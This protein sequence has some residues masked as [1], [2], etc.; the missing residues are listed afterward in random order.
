[1]VRHQAMQ[2]R[3]TNIIFD[4][5]SYSADVPVHALTQIHVH[6]MYH[7]TGM[8][9]LHTHYTAVYYFVLLVHVYMYV[10]DHVLCN[11]CVR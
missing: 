1:M 5:V 4:V 7:S 11:M 10:R 2:M 3:G 6:T 9:Q 8:V